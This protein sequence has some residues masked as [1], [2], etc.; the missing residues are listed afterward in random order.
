MVVQYHM[1]GAGANC[2]LY[3]SATRD[4]ILFL[5]EAEAS[6]TVSYNQECVQIWDNQF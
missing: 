5:F 4:L 6:Y 1:L 3:V 2:V